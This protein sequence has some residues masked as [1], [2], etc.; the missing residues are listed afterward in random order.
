MRISPGDL[1]D[2]SAAAI[3]TAANTPVARNVPIHPFIELLRDKT[4]LVI[5][6][7]YITGR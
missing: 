3:C 5:F 6:I 7:M 4:G 2:P 1:C